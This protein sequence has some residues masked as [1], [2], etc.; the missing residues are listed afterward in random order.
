MLKLNLSLLLLAVLSG[1]AFVVPESI[2]SLSA[3]HAQAIYVKHIKASQAVLSFWQKDN[4][5]WHK[6]LQYSAVIG[7]TGFAKEGQK[8]E[9]DGHTPSGVYALATAFGYAATAATGLDYIQ[10]MSDDFWVDDPKSAQYNQW[11]KGQPQADSFEVLKRSDNL[12][13]LAVVINYNTNPI[14]SGNG[15]AIFL[16]IWRRYDHPTSG[17]VALSERHL[18]KMLKRLD[19]RQNP[20]IILKKD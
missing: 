20:V 13:A 11:I 1:C 16:H 7:R 12:Y 9:G 17:C 6:S 19:K 5:K 10:T 4:N 18:R 14:V 3:D 15:S 2:Q 8:K